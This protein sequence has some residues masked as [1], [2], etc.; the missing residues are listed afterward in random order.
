MHWW[1]YVNEENSIEFEREYKIQS[2]SGNISICEKW[3]LQNTNER[4]TKREPFTIGKATGP[5][6]WWWPE[7]RRWKRKNR[8][9]KRFR[10]WYRFKEIWRIFSRWWMEW[11][12]LVDRR[13]VRTVGLGGL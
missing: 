13:Y 9:I 2:V 12:G 1:L 5:I 11:M 3:W 4:R 6:R 7:P 10:W 8:N